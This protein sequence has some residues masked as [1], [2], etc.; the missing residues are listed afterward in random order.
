MNRE[1]HRILPDTAVW[2]EG[3][4]NVGG[5]RIADLAAVYSTPLYLYDEETLRTGARRVLS[6]FASLKTRVSFAAKACEILAVLRVFCDEGLGLDV[7]SGGEMEAARRAGF[8][9]DRLHLHGNCKSREEI[10]E[11][12]A[13]GVHAIVLDNLEEIDTVIAACRN[14]GGKAGV[15]LRLALPLEAETHPHLQ[16]SGRLT[17]FGLFHTS[18]EEETALDTIARAPEL[19][20]VGIHAHLGSQISQARIYGRAAETL[21]SFAASLNE[22]GLE[23]REVSVGGGWAVAYRQNDP[24]LEPESVMAAIAPAFA[25][26]PEIRP[27][28]EP[29]RAL[30]ARAGLAI[31]RVGAVKRAG[32]S[33]L[34]SVDGGMGDNLRP[35]LYGARYAAV[36]P[37]RMMSAAIGSASIVGRYCESGDVLA[38]DVPLG[39]V[40]AGDLICIPMSGA[41]QLSMSSNYNLVP[42][43]AVVMVRQGQ[44]RLIVRR[45]TRED[46]FAREVI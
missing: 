14:T 2:G 10:E 7:V 25:T 28:V 1:L 4:L 23:I 38:H 24:W 37:D 5:C 41:Y 9:A 6:A 21:V 3:E 35:A 11:A 13:A 20:L 42:A 43:P 31:Y 30:V 26:R 44:A 19:D 18:L 29:G 34:V 36:L 45:E 8:P 46:L 39:Q 17:K 27:A 22:R 15:M 32:E 12:V 40:E 33:R 16:T